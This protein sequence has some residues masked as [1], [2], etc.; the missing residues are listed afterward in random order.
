MSQMTLFGKE[1]RTINN[2]GRLTDGNVI[3]SAATGPVHIS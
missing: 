3:S 2:E 1:R